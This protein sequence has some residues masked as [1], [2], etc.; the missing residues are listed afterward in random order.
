MRSV[1][2]T[3]YPFREARMRDGILSSLPRPSLLSPA[4]PAALVG[5]SA[6]SLPPPAS[7]PDSAGSVD[8]VIEPRRTHD[9]VIEPGMPDVYCTGAGAL[10]AG[11]AA[12]QSRPGRRDAGQLDG[13]D[14]LRCG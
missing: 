9:D 13:C 12:R 7:G 1:H 3:P 11:R 8:N 4:L 5:V 6:T 14:A 10:E 2:N